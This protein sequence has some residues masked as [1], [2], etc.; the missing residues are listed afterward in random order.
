MKTE[1]EK[2]VMVSMLKACHD[3]IKAIW[4]KQ[5]LA[6]MIHIIDPETLSPPKPNLSGEHITK[7]IVAATRWLE[8]KRKDE[9][10]FAI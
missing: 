2:K 10:L 9:E 8:G 5:Q 6:V 3:D 4:E 7:A 1:Y